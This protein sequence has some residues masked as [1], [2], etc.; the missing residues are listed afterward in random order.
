[1]RCLLWV[2]GNTLGSP[3]RAADFHNFRALSPGTFV[4]FQKENDID[5]NIRNIKFVSN[6]NRK[7]SPNTT[8]IKKELIRRKQNIKN[9]Q[10]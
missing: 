4:H 1:M 3:G 9:I 5:I 10:E 8:K 2:P 7:R 6:K